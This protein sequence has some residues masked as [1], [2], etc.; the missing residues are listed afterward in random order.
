MDKRSRGI[1]KNIY[2]DTDLDA[3]IERVA[4]EAFEGNYSM[5][6][7]SLLRTALVTPLVRPGMIVDDEG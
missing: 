7:R 6:I 4:A 5:A 2:L 1:P 3:E